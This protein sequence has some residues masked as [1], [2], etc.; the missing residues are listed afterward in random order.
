MG[1]LGIGLTEYFAFK[2]WGTTPS[3]TLQPDTQS[4][5]IALGKEEAQRLWT[6]SLKRAL[7]Q[8][9]WQKRGGAVRLHV[10]WNVELK[11][12]RILPW[13]RGPL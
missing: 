10:K 3:G 11:F 1:E 8:R 6:S 2:Q 4:K 7:N 13:H 5:S 9:S 12:R